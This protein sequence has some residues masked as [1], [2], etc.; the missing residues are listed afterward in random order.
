MATLVLVVMVGAARCA[1]IH[2]DEMTKRV[3]ILNAEGRITNVALFDDVFVSD[4]ITHVDWTTDMRKG[5]TYVDGTHTPAPVKIPGSL[6][7]IQLVNAFRAL[8]YWT[9]AKASLKQASTL[10]K[11]DWEYTNRFKRRNHVIAHFV[12]AL[13]ITDD[14]MNAVFLDGNDR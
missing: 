12:A 9:S 5:D 7:K 4:G 3:A 2:G 1:Y 14:D 6:T 10:V 8:G 13:S 11:E